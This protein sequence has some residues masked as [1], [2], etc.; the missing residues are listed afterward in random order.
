MTRHASA[1]AAV[2]TGNVP[3]WLA[4]LGGYLSTPSGAA[5]VAVTVAVSVGVVVLLG[6]A[7]RRTRRPVRRPGRPSGAGALITTAIVMSAVVAGVGGARSFNAVSD[8]FDSVLVPLVVDGMIIACTALRLAALTRGW[9]IPGALVTTWVFIGGT[10]WLN[11]DTAV[12]VAD[13][14]AHAL[15]PIAY[16]VLVEM[17]AHLLRLHLKLAQPAR[18]KLSALTWIT[19]PVITTRVWLHLARTGTDDPVVA[20]ALVQQVVRMASRLSTVCPSPL[21]RPFG[22]ARAARSAAL[23][24]IR[25]GLLTAGDLA[26][27]LPTTGQMTAGQLLALV[28]GAALGIIPTVQDTGTASDSSEAVDSLVGTGR[29]TVPLATLT[30][31]LGRATERPTPVPAAPA[32]SPSGAPV[33]ESTPAPER[34]GSDRTA[35]DRTGAPVHHE[36]RTGETA[37]TQTRS[38]RRRRRHDR[39][40]A[41]LAELHRVS[42]EQYNGAPL[43]QREIMRVLACGT[44]K[45]RRL[46]AVA[47]WAPAPDAEVADNAELPE[48]VADTPERSEVDGQLPLPPEAFSPVASDP[49][50]SGDAVVAAARP[51][52]VVANDDDTDQPIEREFETSS[53]R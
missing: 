40:A 28:D 22:A 23:Q 53:H 32:P 36:D 13:A 49:A 21:L 18:A 20:R 46:E 19:S 41:D 3:D 44:P 10:V 24:T 50:P 25:D 39:D 5:L 52:V 42:V 8:K 11:V 30:Y 27:K 26:A 31:L 34:T 15:A 48:P 37:P 7:A 16:A 9:R 6:V 43:S 17:L 33:G 51:G 2:A 35:D 38:G 47:G 45:A 12:G 14:V 4:Q 1:L 29:V